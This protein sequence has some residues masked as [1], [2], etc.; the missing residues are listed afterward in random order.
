MAK[1]YT[2]RLGILRKKPG[3]TDQQFR[4][5]WLNVH[6]KLCLKLPKMR[7]KIARL[8][9]EI[10]QLIRIVEFTYH[11]HDRFI[12]C[13]RESVDQIRI[14]KRDLERSRKGCDLCLRC[15]RKA[16]E[17]VDAHSRRRAA[18]TTFPHENWILDEGRPGR[19][20]VH[21]LH[22]QADRLAVQVPGE[23]EKVR[24]WQVPGGELLE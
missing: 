18:G 14:N 21:C 6:A 1:T 11:I 3:M 10:S 8:R 20:R 15:H 9:I 19:L 13:I 4:D 12:N 23:V 17:A 24:C 7:R 22:E 16:F 2:K 5:H